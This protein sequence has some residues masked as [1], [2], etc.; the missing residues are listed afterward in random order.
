MEDNSKQTDDILSQSSNLDFRDYGAYDKN[1]YV[2]AIISPTDKPESTQSVKKFTNTEEAQKFIEELTFLRYSFKGSFKHILLDNDFMS[3]VEQ[4]SNQLGNKPYTNANA[5]KEIE[6][7]ILKGKLLV[8]LTGEWVPSEA[9]NHHRSSNP[10]ESNANPVKQDPKHSLGPETENKTDETIESRQ[11]QNSSLRS[12]PRFEKDINRVG[13][14]HSQIKLMFD[15]K[16]PLGF[17]DEKQFAQFKKELN[18]ALNNA[19][20]SDA[21]IGLKGTATTFYSENPSKKLGH[22]WDAD[23]DPAKKGD[24][25]L[26]ITSSKMV[27][28]MEK[29]NISP[30]PKYNVFKTKDINKSFPALDTFQ[31]KWSKTLDRDV[32]FV[33]YP[34]KTARDSTEYILRQ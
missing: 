13:V 18:T 34:Q 8:F 10:K 12:S 14:T 22:H 20:L 11:Q 4:S 19:E 2:Y 24:Y 5:A 31:K 3:D 27:N 16:V 15:K 23:P 7:L 9:R 17:K 25:D 26:N 6:R 33:G 32:N 28:T 1:G 30:H 21:Q 29:S